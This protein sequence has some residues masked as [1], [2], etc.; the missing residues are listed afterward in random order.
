[1]SA[2]CP[3]CA[4][5][6]LTTSNT[7]RCI[8]CEFESCKK[9]AKA[10]QLQSIQDPSCMKC[11][12]LYTR[13]EG[14]Q[15]FGKAFV[16]GYLKRHRENVLL[17]REMA[18]MPATVPYVAREKK[19]RESIQRML[20]L[21]RRRRMLRQALV[22]VEVEIGSLVRSARTEDPPP[23]EEAVYKCSRNGCAGYL[24]ASKKCLSCDRHTCIHCD[25]PKDGDDHVCKDEDVQSVRVVRKE[26]RPCPSCNI[27]I[28]RTS[29]CDQM[30]CT[31]CKC[32]FSWRTGSRLHGTVHNP[33]YYEYLRANSNQHVPRNPLD[34]PCGDI[35]TAGELLRTLS[36]CSVHNAGQRMTTLHIHRLVVHVRDHE[37]PLY[38]VEQESEETNRD[39]RILYCLNELDT[40]SMK[41]QLQRREKRSQKLREIRS[42]LEMFYATTGDLLRQFTLGEIDSLSECLT[43]ITQLIHYF[44]TSMLDVSRFFSCRVPLV[45]PNLS[46]RSASFGDSSD[47]WTE[48]DVPVHK[49]NHATS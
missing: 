6:R 21:K 13:A 33:H 23:K 10:F 26:A 8:A 37:I 43:E 28:S 35:P 15:A 47:A 48:P 31:L 12:R 19:R 24:D 7:I 18:M 44:N 32:T 29:G 22:D 39:L 25:S 11:R 45:A 41:I 14:V 46:I 36:S 34:I 30:W 2:V 4:D 49:S 38:P 27:M 17:E 40:T 20:A 9:C 42:I 16:Q 1:M 5:H 3:V